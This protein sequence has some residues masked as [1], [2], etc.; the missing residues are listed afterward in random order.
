LVRPAI[1][2][3][4]SIFLAASARFEVD[5]VSLDLGGQRVLRE[6]TLQFDAT[7]SV[8]IVG[9]SGAGKTSLLRL[10]SGALFP[11]SGTVQLDGQRFSSL[12]QQGSALRRMRAQV[13]FV[14]QDFA[15]VPNLRVIQNVVSGGFSRRGFWGALRDLVVPRRQLQQEVFT[16]LEHLGIGDKL[17][18]RVD[19]LS[20][21]QQQRVALARALFQKPRALLADEPVSS[22][23]PSRAR[24]LL[25]LL[26]RVA[27]ERQLPLVVSL[28]DADLARALFA[29]V[30][31][32][33]DGR[34]VFDLP[35]SEVDR[36]RLQA[37]YLLPESVS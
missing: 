18:Q 6:V 16:L 15:L 35:A 37:L 7:Q 9:P 26:H 19:T 3:P 8:A 29:R 12:S 27:A 5:Q 10:L 24:D 14:H 28:H 30:I 34:V 1:R 33:R 11:D 31:G 25:E 21:G 4:D 22:V 36:E 17:F 2:G 13:G 23:D 20:G 32:L